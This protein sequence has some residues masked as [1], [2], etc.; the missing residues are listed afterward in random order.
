VLFSAA[1]TKIRGLDLGNNKT[2][3]HMQIED[4]DDDEYEDD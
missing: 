4:E 3:H 2:T 1:S